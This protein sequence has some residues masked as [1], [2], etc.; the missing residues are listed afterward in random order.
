ML[1]W[2]ILIFGVPGAFI[3]TIVFYVVLKISEYFN[4][5]WGK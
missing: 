2:V 1:E 4:N 3:L 5:R